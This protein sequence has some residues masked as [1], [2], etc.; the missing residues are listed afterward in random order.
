MLSGDRRFSRWFFALFAIQD[1]AQILPTAFI[2]YDPR[3]AKNRW[4]VPDMLAMSAGQIRHPMS[5]FILMVAHD[6][7]IHA[8]LPFGS[9]ES[10]TLLTLLKRQ[11]RTIGGRQIHPSLFLVAVETPEKDHVPVQMAKF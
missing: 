11:F 10:M 7:L 6:R 5:F 3:T 9:C 2:R 1:A 8:R 4:V